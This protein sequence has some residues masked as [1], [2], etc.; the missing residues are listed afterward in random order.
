MIN[1]SFGCN[2]CSFVAMWLVSSGASQAIGSREKLIMM[3]VL[4]RGGTRVSHGNQAFNANSSGVNSLRPTCSVE[5]S[6]SCSSS[7]AQSYGVKQKIRSSKHRGQMGPVHTRGG[8]PRPIVECAVASIAARGSWKPPS[9]TTWRSPTLNLGR[10]SG[11]RPRM[12][13][14]RPSHDFV[15]EPLTQ[16]TR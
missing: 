12:K 8:V 14:W 4:Q 1:R 16:D 7:I 11:P 13:S 3:G 10:L 6:M 15:I 9:R 2:C 5:A